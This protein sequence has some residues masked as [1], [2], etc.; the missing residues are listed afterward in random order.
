[1]SGQLF[2]PITT[3]DGFTPL[4][5]LALVH[6][7]EYTQA[8]GCRIGFDSAHYVDCTPEQAA[9]VAKR[10]HPYVIQT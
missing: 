3:Q 5:N 10:L 4:V 6:M 2:L 9:V 1:M 8:G 7:I